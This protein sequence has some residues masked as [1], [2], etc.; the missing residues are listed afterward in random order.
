MAEA[1]QAVQKTGVGREP[2]GGA[3]GAKKFPSWDSRTF[4]YFDPK[5]RKPSLYESVTVDVLPD[6]DRH[7]LQGWV[8]EFADGMEA[9]DKRRTVIK[10]S[11]WHAYRA[12]DAEWERN[13]YQR[14]ADVESMIKQVV[15]RG[16]A[17][18]ASEK[19]DKMW[20]PILG[21]HFGALK[22]AEYGLHRATMSGQ[23]DG[24]TQ[25]VNNSILTHATHKIRLAQDMVLYL[26]EIGADID[27]DLDAGKKA[28]MEDPAWQGTRE[29]IEKIIGTADYLEQYFAINLVCEPLVTEAMRSGFFMQFAAP[30]SDFMTPVILSAAENDYERD[31]A[32]AIE[33]F[34]LHAHD[35]EC[36][37]E[38]RKIM[39]GWLEKWVPLAVAA[40]EN[41]QPVWS[42]PR[43][44]RIS[45]AD[46]YEQAK[47]RMNTALSEV[48]IELP[49]SVKV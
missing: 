44:K 31:L 3:R 26:A 25:M 13:H 21:N 49:E 48:G 39:A 18:N 32:N 2:G 41:L 40:I 5:G 17:T 46:V 19:F 4:N 20:R 29:L 27:L 11:D 10:S 24:V 30:H 16:I 37:D 36:G 22:H 47:D 34:N 33:M 7:L 28:W 9:Y 23:R 45:F 14:Q 8:I 35:P 1:E 38:N 42:Q 12:P 6:P 43:V 15:D